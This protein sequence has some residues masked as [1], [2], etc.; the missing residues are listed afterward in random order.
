MEKHHV[1]LMKA[2]TV[3]ASKVLELASANATLG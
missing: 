1:V 2:Y 3:C